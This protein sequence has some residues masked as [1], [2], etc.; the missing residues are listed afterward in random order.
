MNEETLK[1]TLLEIIKEAD[2]LSRDELELIPNTRIWVK[3]GRVDEFKASARFYY[4]QKNNVKV[5]NDDYIRDV[6]YELAN[7]LAEE[8]GEHI[9]SQAY[10]LYS[11]NSNDLTRLEALNKSLKMN[12]VDKE[13]YTKALDELNKRNLSNPT[14]WKEMTDLQNSLKTL[15]ENET[16]IKNAIAEIKTNV[17]DRVKK[18]V[19]EEMDFIKNSYLNT[20]AGT[21]VEFGLDGVSILAKDKE[22][23]DNL[24][25]LL[26]IIENVNEK[27][28]I[29]CVDNTICVNPHQVEAV[30]ELL[31]KIDFLKL[32][33]KE[34]KEQ[35]VKEVKKPNEDLIKQIAKELERLSDKIA[36]EKRPEDQSEY[37][38]LIKILNY[39][40]KADNYK[41]DLMPVWNAYVVGTDRQAFLDVAKKTK[42]FNEYNSDLEKI[43]ENEDLIK[44]LKEYLTTLEDKVKNYR[45]Q[46]NVPLSRV[47]D[48]VILAND[49]MEYANVLAMISILENAKEDL[50]SVEGKGNV[51]YKDL[52][53]YRELIEKTKYFTPNVT[54]PNVKEKNEAVM[55]QTK[56]ELKNLL[57]KAQNSSNIGKD[58]Q[59]IFDNISQE[60]ELL[61][62]KLDILKN[63][64]EHLQ[65]VEIDGA[66]VNEDKASEYSQILEEI[67]TVREAA[68]ALN[69]KTGDEPE[70]PS[71][72]PET[73]DEPEVLPLDPDPDD[74]PEVLPLDPDPD[75]EPE[76]LPLDPEKDINDDI[77]KRVADEIKT[78]EA[79]ALGSNPS[80]LASNKKVLARDR[81]L[82]DL[83]N[84]KLDILKMAKTAD[85][86]VMVNGAKIPSDK[87]AE[88]NKLNS[89]IAKLKQPKKKEKAP[90]RKAVKSVRKAKNSS[91]WKENKKKVIGIGLAIIVT[92]WA[93][94]NLVPT[95]VY[96]NSCLATA[97]PSLG[98]ITGGINSFLVKTFNISMGSLNFNVAASSAFSAMAT[99]LA[100]VGIIGGGVTY[101]VKKIRKNRK[102][103]EK[104]LD[105]TSL[106]K[107]IKELGTLKKV[108]ELSRDL[109]DKAS[110]L[111]DNL[112]NSVDNSQL[113]LDQ[114]GA[115]S[116][117]GTVRVEG[118]RPVTIN[119]P[120]E[121]EIFSRISDD[122]V[123]KDTDDYI[124]AINENRL[125]EALEY[126]KR[127]LEKT[128]IDLG[129][130]NMRSA[131]DVKRAKDDIAAYL[132]HKDSDKEM[133]RGI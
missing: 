129:E 106:I 64:D 78:L 55:E 73:N 47:Q 22:L 7:L 46:A 109:G 15:F 107:Q 87:L 122:S 6:Y 112:V 28:T 119:V 19:Q 80:E 10:D 67:K 17:N 59:I 131:L 41:F 21:N 26:R 12:R 61:K 115:S 108:K 43:R 29:I 74:E 93:L 38:N 54:L 116:E 120:S 16:F 48:A 94:S 95:I 60:L 105:K 110:S 23:Y 20:K 69:L 104:N 14:I 70:I 4:E 44:D 58:K 127:V 77:I 62:R 133:K 33:K 103:S 81:E 1:T 86:L 123:Y 82:Y 56:Q 97:F 51:S 3:K 71:L 63:V 101:I 37:D 18:V 9:I 30:K 39:L 31:P 113:A 90:I 72:D 121:E 24:Y 126:Q 130:Y 75:D 57:D 32:I 11:A 49:Q 83:L 85:N 91:W 79:Y 25:V 8:K 84:K 2:N 89:E 117:K 13:K 35:E 66:L 111:I 52:P 34:E 118:S 100:K 114:A 99:A 76:V 98:G 125:D 42:F 45:G 124:A 88:Y 50:I 53:K 36:K 5:E 65:L 128:G 68:Q 27:D 92:V 102:D 40:N 96:A 132:N